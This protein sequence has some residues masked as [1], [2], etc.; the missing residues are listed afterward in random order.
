MNYSNKR[1]EG[2]SYEDYRE[3]LKFLNR[4]KK[5]RS[6]LV[7]PSESAGTYTKNTGENL[8]LVGDQIRQLV[9]AELEQYGD[10]EIVDKDSEL[11]EENKDT[12]TEDPKSV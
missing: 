12:G 4:L 9:K 3:R 10:W 6:I 5:N 7:W 2:E 8:S 11:L 1:Q